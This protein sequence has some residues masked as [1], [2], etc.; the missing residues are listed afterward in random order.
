MNAALANAIRKS[1]PMTMLMQVVES[2]AKKF[3]AKKVA[4]SSA[5]CGISRLL[6]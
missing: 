6:S 1:E 2:E 5:Q 3:N 4:H